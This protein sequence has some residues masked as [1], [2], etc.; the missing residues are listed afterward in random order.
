VALHLAACPSCAADWRL[1]MRAEREEAA[2]PA[3]AR[4]AV[5]RAG[6]AAQWT[7]L[8]A[9][10]VLLLAALVVTV[11]R[12][13]DPATGGPVYR[14]PDAISIRALTPDQASVPR[15]EALLRWSPVG[16]DALY[17]VEVGTL[18]LVPLAAAQD[19]EVTEYLVPAA[20]LE[21]VSDGE[22][23][24]WQVEASLPDGRRVASEAFVVRIE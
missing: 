21:P 17:S 13:G 5:S 19:L 4:P 6:R 2:A 14:D 8:A 12:V 18:D 11:S 22:S 1:A 7:A 23:I 3:P 10:A 20:A 9:A 24:V 16:E 15:D